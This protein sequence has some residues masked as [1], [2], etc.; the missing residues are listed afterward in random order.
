MLST[1]AVVS[2]LSVLV[3]S[4][5][6]LL[7]K[8][9]SS[10]NAAL[11]TDINAIMRN[12]GQIT[13]YAD[14]AENY[15]GVMDVGLPD[16]CQVEQAHLL[17][18]HGA[19]F[20][21]STFDDGAND[22]NFGQK[23]HNWTAANPSKKFSGPLTFLN[24]YQYTM[25]ES[26]LVG[27]GAAQSFSAGVQFWQRYGR[28]LFN[29]TAG[30]IAYNASYA[31]GTA[32]PKPVL[33]TTGQ[34]RIENSEINWA[35]GFFGPSF[36]VDPNPNITNATA[37]YNVVVI[38]E[39]GTENNTLA[40]YDSCFKADDD[41]IGFLGDIDLEPYIPKYLQNATA[42][43]QQYAPAGFNFSVNDTYAM[44]SICAYETNYLGTSD[45][46]YLFTSD[47]WAGFEQTLD[48]EYYYDYAYGNP[49]GRAQGIGYLQE[50]IA[51]LTNTYITSS[52]SSVNSSLTNN[53]QTFPL[54]SKFYADFTH[55]DIIISVLTAMSFDYLKDPPSLTQF[56]PNATRHFILSHLT[57][58]A[59]RFVTEV[60]GCG[61]SS[62]APVHAYRTQYTPNQYGYSSSNAT[63]KFIR[64]R[65][66]NGILPLSTIRG[67]ACGNRTDGMCDLS[68]FVQSQQN[69]YKL[70]NYNY[71]CFGNYTDAHPLS[72]QDFDGAI[73]NTTKT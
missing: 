15:F 10:S 35:L 24:G 31:N 19:R 38:P 65:L 23:I 68:S 30:Q 57:P 8:R 61:A 45:F 26:F 16:G 21:T 6:T 7:D 17:E 20:P 42:R 34:S 62:P 63:H 56:P 14:N 4:S 27:Q 50:L 54:G 46:C 49:T 55:D 44:Q 2:T 39:G 11:L 66:N 25:G 40:S 58:F 72:G 13:P 5:P 3:A 48:Q 28:I 60:I 37:P 36:V 73:T 41:T 59:A 43:M 47:E 64:M 70:S 1:L 9:Q 29:A 51:R 12:W 53:S 32:R 22:E 18:R 67:G 69:A 71:A 33:R 52:N